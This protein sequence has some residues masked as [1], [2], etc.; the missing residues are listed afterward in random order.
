ME[1]NG[2]MG[3]LYRICEWI[4]RLTISNL[5]WFICSIPFLF[6]I[7][8]A[9]NA[10]SFDDQGPFYSSLIL[11]GIAAPFTVFPANAALYSVVRKWMMGEEDVPILKTF[12]KGYKS[13]YL[14]S[15]MGGILFV[16][17]L[18]LFIVNYQFYAAMNNA[19]QVLSVFFILCIIVL[20]VA[21]FYYTCLM[22]H[23]HMKTLALLKNSFFLSIARPITSILIVGIHAVIIYFTFFIYPIL[24]L[25]VTASVLA[26]ATFHLFYRMFNKIQQQAEPTVDRNNEETNETSV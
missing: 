14:Q 16:L 7:L 13:N 9:M 26:F 1:M 12:F 2:L 19:A 6:I 22:V 5:L 10:V 21:V 3:G 20:V 4:Y 17:L 8:M 11:L 23:V 25:L 24:I 15:V 18:G